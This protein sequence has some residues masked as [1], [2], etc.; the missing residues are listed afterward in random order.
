MDNQT[1]FLKREASSGEINV[2]KHFVCDQVQGM[3]SS[4]K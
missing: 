2:E 3:K 1:I 4:E